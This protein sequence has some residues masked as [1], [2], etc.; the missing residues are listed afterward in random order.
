VA[1][2]GSSASDI[3]LQTQILNAKP[4]PNGAIAISQRPVEVGT[5][6]QGP[7]PGNRTQ[8]MRVLSEE[9]GDRKLTI[10]LEGL[11]GTRAQLQVFVRMPKIVVRADG[12]DLSE[13]P[14]HTGPDA[15]GEPQT[16]TAHFP[17]G[18]GWKAIT[19]TLTW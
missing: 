3:K 15:A 4:L 6:F 8:S 2:A 17:A 1:K 5:L 9:Y 14:A 12:A 10:T 13:P 11:A 19:I 18:D 7:L 16:L